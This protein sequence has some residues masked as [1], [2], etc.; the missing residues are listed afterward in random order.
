MIQQIDI[1]THPSQTISSDP[2][3]CKIGQFSRPHENCISDISEKNIS[4]VLNCVCPH[5]END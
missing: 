4:I 5:A 2:I 1:P 3:L